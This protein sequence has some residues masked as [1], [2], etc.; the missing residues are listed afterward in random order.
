MARRD[1]VAVLVAIGRSNQLKQ[2]EYAVAVAVVKQVVTV[3]AAILT[4]IQ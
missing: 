1:A 2:K 4:A 3:V